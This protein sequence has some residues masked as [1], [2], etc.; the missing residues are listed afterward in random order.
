MGGVNPYIAPAKVK[1][2]TK[3]Y[4]VTF[5]PLNKTVEVDPNVGRYG[6]NGLPLSIL[7]ISEGAG[8][9]IDHSCGGVC[10][11]S[12]CHVYITKGLESCSASTEDEEDMLDEAPALTP[13]SRLACQCI[14]SGTMDLEVRIP[15]WNRNQVQEGHH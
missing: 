4:R 6:H 12:T 10:A 9:D 1:P 14:P 3:K 11:C 13:D 15:K 8:V 2:P 7:D 5:L